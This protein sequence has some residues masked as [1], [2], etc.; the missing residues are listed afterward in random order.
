MNKKYFTVFLMVVCLLFLSCTRTWKNPNEALPSIETSIINI[1][2]APTAFDSAGVVVKGMV[3]D[4][5][6]EDVVVADEKYLEDR[7]YATFKLADKRGNFIN[8]Y[9][10]NSFPLKEGNII[11]VLG[12]YRR[13]YKSEKKH[14]INEI[15]AKNIKVLK[16]LEEKYTKQ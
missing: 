10:E 3:W 16:S 1:L 8:I 15:E 11:E 14:F 5:V 7:S 13:N 9:A 2:A 12:I 6:Y 4:L